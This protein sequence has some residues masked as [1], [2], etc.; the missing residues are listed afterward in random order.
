MGYGLSPLYH[1]YC[2]S[3]FPKSESLW[4]V[5]EERISALDQVPAA[6]RLA[7]ACTARRRVSAYLV[8]PEISR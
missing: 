3:L 1:I 8:P 2:P 5:W 4:Q 7:T 6:A